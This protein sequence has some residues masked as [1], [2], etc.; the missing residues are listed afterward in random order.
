MNTH[1][2]THKNSSVCSHLFLSCMFSFQCSW[3]RRERLPASTLKHVTAIDVRDAACLFK[4][5]RRE[6]AAS[7]RHSTFW[8]L[9][10]RRRAA[11]WSFLWLQPCLLSKWEADLESGGLK[12]SL[13]LFEYCCFFPNVCLVIFSGG[14]ALCG[15]C[16]HP[17]AQ[18]KD[19]LHYLNTHAQLYTAVEQH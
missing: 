16:H 10:L 3:I 12:L 6:E 9:Y 8:C 17:L 1:T 4:V 19:P 15:V 11:L 2:H 13:F 5:G 7:E 14:N 18:D